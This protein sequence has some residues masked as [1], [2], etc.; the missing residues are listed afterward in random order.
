MKPTSRGVNRTAFP[1]VLLAFTLLELLV[2]M[3]ILGI[4]AALLLPAVTRAKM[5]AHQIKCLSNVKQLSLASFMYAEDQG[6][7]PGYNDPAYPGGLWMGSLMAY[8]KAKDLR[9]CPSAPLR[10]PH[11][12]AGNGQGSADRAWVRWTTN[13]QTMFFGS[14]GYNGWLYSDG[15]VDGTTNLI[16]HEFFFT[17]ESSIQKPSLTPV[18]LDENWVDLWPLEQDLPYDDLYN[19]SPYTDHSSEMGRCT[20][21]RH[22]SSSPNRAPRDHPSNQKMPGAINMGMADG[23]AELVKLEDLWHYFWHL[24][25]QPPATRPQ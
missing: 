10:S 12:L 8:A 13:N 25:W 2:V 1:G 7:H 19:G 6:R 3:A 24:D 21:A 15:R 5:K 22:G 14:Y 4:L 9:V 18:F 16:H 11:V 20:I 23:H 17:R